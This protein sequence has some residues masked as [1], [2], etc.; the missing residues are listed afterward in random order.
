MTLYIGEGLRESNG[1]HSTLHGISDT[2]SATHNQIGPLWCWFP[3]GWTCAHS[4]PLWV[5][6]TNS[7]VRLGISPAAASTLTGVFNHRF[8]ALFPGAGALGC[9]VCFAPLPFLPVYLSVNVGPHSGHHLVGSASC[10]LA[11]PIPQSTTS[12]G[13]PATALLQ[14]LSAPAACVCPSYWYG[15]M[16]PLYL[17]GC[18]TFTQFYFLSVM[19]VFCF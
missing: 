14:V 7:P 11:C 18:W 2:P 10:S 9:V 17:F 3:S 16:F 19:I 5:S 12:L 8:E 1:A 13:P 6:G 15:Q 4:R